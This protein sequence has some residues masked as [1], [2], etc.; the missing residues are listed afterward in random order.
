MYGQGKIEPADCIRLGHMIANKSLTNLERLN[1]T[2]NE[3]PSRF[4][5]ALSQYVERAKIAEQETQQNKR[6]LI[7]RLKANYETK[8]REKEGSLIAKFQEEVQQIQS[9]HSVETAEVKRRELVVLRE[10]LSQVENTHVSMS[11]SKLSLDKAASVDAHKI[12]RRW[13]VLIGV[14]IIAQLVLT[15]KYGWNVMEPWTYFIGL[16][17]VIGAYFY[18]AYTKKEASP[19]GIWDAILKSKKAKRYSNAGFD[20]EFFASLEPTIDAVREKIEARNEK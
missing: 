1:V 10:A 5:E 19:K 15:I 6:A 2:A 9:A 8:L 17:P 18:F 11:K 14:I 4:V 20:E 7:L 16:V 3:S 12:L 13:V